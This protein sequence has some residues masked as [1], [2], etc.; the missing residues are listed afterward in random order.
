MTMTSVGSVHGNESFNAAGSN[1]RMPHS[2]SSTRSPPVD[3]NIID[4]IGLT[5]TMMVAPMHAATSHHPAFSPVRTTNV[6]AMASDV[7]TASARASARDV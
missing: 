4:G 3:A 7:E 1:K 6:P 5:N 2:R